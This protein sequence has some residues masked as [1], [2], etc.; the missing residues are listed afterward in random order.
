MNIYVVQLIVYFLSTVLV[1]AMVVSLMWDYP[2]NR[3]ERVA[4]AAFIYCAL[5]LPALA[6]AI[7]K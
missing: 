1:E 3:I 5:W 7:R 6:L 2:Y 4:V